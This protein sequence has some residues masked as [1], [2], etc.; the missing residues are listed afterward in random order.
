MQVYQANRRVLASL[1]NSMT[2]SFM[3]YKKFSWRLDVEV[4]TNQKFTINIKLNF[5]FCCFS[6]LGRRNIHT[7][8]SPK[9]LLRLDLE[10]S[11]S[12][13]L[14]A[15][16]SVHIQSDFAN[17]KRLQAELQSAVDEISSVHSQRISRYIT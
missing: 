16:Q 13:S 17:L 6:Q 9:F 3:Q 10:N 5:R 11:G 7:M 14:N 2:I 4:I 15:A 8:T 12:S 1:K